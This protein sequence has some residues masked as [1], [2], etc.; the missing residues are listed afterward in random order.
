M[1]DGACVVLDAATDAK[2]ATMVRRPLHPA[3]PPPPWSRVRVL[4]D[5]PPRPSSS[6]PPPPVAS[7]IAP[8]RRS[9]TGAD[10]G[11]VRVS[12]G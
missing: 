7:C 5:R 12:R 8:S 4:P 6:R 11:A 10:R 1:C 2:T 3:R 9:A